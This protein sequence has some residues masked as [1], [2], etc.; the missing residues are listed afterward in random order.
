MR[1]K[2]RSAPERSTRMA[3]PGYLASNALAMRSATGRS[4][5]VYQTT[6]PSFLAASISSGVTL[7]GAGAAAD[8]GRQASGSV[9]GAA[10]SPA[11]KRRRVS[12]GLG[13]LFPPSSFLRHQS[14]PGR[15]RRQQPAR[16]QRTDDKGPARPAVPSSALAM[17]AVPISGARSRVFMSAGHETW[18][19][20]LANRADC[21]NSFQIRLFRETR[22]FTSSRGGLLARRPWPHIA[23][24]QHP[25]NPNRKS[26]A[27]DIVA[28]SARRSCGARPA[29]ALA[30]RVR[31]E[32][33]QCRGGRAASAEGDGCQ[34][35]QTHGRR[36]GRVRRP[37]RRRRRRRGAGAR[38]GLS[39]RH[40]LP[41]RP[42]GEERRPA[43][44]HRSPPLR[45]R[46]RPE[47]GEPRP[48]ARQPR[49]R[50]IRPQARA[51][52]R[53]RQRPSPS[54]PSISARRPSASP[55]RR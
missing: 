47:R 10:V 28:Q 2:M 9:S 12:V 11:T 34:A 22:G 55:T 43:L 35:R 19:W 27:E 15:H 41:G 3:M 17:R 40:P 48:G 25:I 42:A 16:R 14:T 7:L 26:D 18:P 51:R 4:T 49:V 5:D 21:G 39:R 6:L 20:L 24:T 53:A 36:P 52:A 54:R 50:R 1:W 45:G 13:M 30:C 8:A 32:P 38:V 33:A 44:H 29:R 46:V 23:A 37:L 31:A